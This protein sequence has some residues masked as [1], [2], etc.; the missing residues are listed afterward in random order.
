MTSITDFSPN[1]TDLDYT[2]KIYVDTKVAKIGADDIEITD[3]NKGIILTSP[4]SSRYRITVDNSGN[5]ITTLI[6]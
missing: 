4:N 1:I 3:F 6:P 5:L 2:Q